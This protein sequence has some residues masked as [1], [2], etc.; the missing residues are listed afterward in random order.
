MANE[1]NLI[2]NNQPIGDIIPP[3]NNENN[4]DVSATLFKYCHNTDCDWYNAPQPYSR[5][6]C[7]ECGDPLFTTPA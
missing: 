2:D 7:F 4:A 5:T 6:L 3:E 1:E